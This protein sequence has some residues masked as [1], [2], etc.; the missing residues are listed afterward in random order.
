MSL[1]L[2]EGIATSELDKNIVQQELIK[3]SEG[4]QK[5]GHLFL[6]PNTEAI[7]E[8]LTICKEN[9]VP[10]D[11]IKII[12]PTRLDS[13]KFNPFV[14]EKEVAAQSFIKSLNSIQ[15]VT[16]NFIKGMQ[17]SAVKC[18]ILLAKFAYGNSTNIT[19][20]QRLFTDTRHLAD[21]VEDTRRIVDT[22][23]KTVTNDSNR[24]KELNAIEQ[25]VVYFENEVLEYKTYKLKDQVVEVLYPPDHQYAGK[26]VVV[27][28]IEN[29]VQMIKLYLTDITLNP[30]LHS[31]F[32]CESDEELFDFDAFLTNGGIVLVNTCLAKLEKIG[33]LF[34]HL[35]MNQFQSAV[36]HTYN[37][38]AEQIPIS[39]YISDLQRF[40]FDSFASYLQYGGPMDVIHTRQQSI[41]DANTIYGCI[42]PKG[43]KNSNLSEYLYIFKNI[44]QYTKY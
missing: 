3:V 29:Y 9:G 28:K 1:E 30:T 18:S 23:R 15:D 8:V 43:E 36:I 25:L 32:V 41:T 14:G 13:L 40:N 35:F 17:S 38:G 5:M 16:N 42:T 26:Q 31:I 24:L 37:G 11:K 19:H 44:L 33:L 20:I 10:N 22:N 6:V 7:D 39:F 4:T 34:G 2:K 27:N 12:D 21:L